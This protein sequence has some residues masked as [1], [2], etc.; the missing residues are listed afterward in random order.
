MGCALGVVYG[1]TG[2]SRASDEGYYKDLFI[3]CGRHLLC[4]TPHAANHLK[5]SHERMRPR[6]V[7]EQN[8]LLIS[9]KH[10]SN[11][12]LLYPD[13]APRFRAIYVNGGE[14][15]DHGR[16]LGQKGLQRV[17]D[18]FR[19]G[20]SYTGSCAG[21]FIA[22]A[23]RMGEAMQDTYFSI[24]PGET[25]ET[26]YDKKPS[27]WYIGP[28]GFRL[29]KDSPLLK[30]NTFG[31]DLYVDAIKHYEGPY[32]LESE[33]WPQGTEV[34]ARFDLPKARFHNTPSIWAYQP[35]GGSGRLVVVASHPENYA[36]GERR[37]LMA[38]ILQ[39]A[40]AGTGQ[41]RLK[42]RLQ[43]GKSI[44]MRQ[45]T[46]DQDPCRTKIGDGQIH[47]FVLWVP[48]GTKSIELRLQGDARLSTGESA[49]LDL[50]AQAKSP[51]WP[52]KASHSAKGSSSAETLQISKPRPGVWY[53]AVHGV[54]R[55]KP[56]VEH[57]ALSYHA[58]LG[59]LNGVG[60]TIQADFGSGKKPVSA[61]RID[62]VSSPKDPWCDRFLDDT[63]SL[64]DD[65]MDEKDEKGEKGEEDDSDEDSDSTS[66]ENE[67]DQSSSDAKNKSEKGDSGAD[68]S[69]AAESSSDGEDEP[70]QS[71][72]PDA[73][74]AKLNNPASSRSC[75]L[76]ASPEK[77]P[78]VWTLVLG[79][80]VLRR[81]RRA[82]PSG[83]PRF[84]LLGLWPAKRGRTKCARIMP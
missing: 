49:K 45:S 8:S 70:E 73:N 78:L 11:G 42:G 32:A 14:S 71:S 40:L 43:P 35:E 63:K 61:H 82:Y 7:S 1:L 21:A 54:N 2:T 24:W 36:S 59:A 53:V 16:T 41:P 84:S 81:N 30:Y 64:G 34:L 17:R 80:I 72:E 60:Y 3:D 22:S 83:Y 19:A 50:Y 15:K 52:S 68:A 23:R 37:D 57:D 39:Y 62:A 46:E 75:S 10:D 67:E 77:R 76:H 18:Y 13:G 38:A 9:D 65:D 5:L 51:A 58:N 66:G 28:T 69:D 27:S 26:W 48:K 12:V 25:R 33:H 74:A 31:D 29:D 20:G 55:V 47:H 79:A 56:R 44:K 4:P 6:S